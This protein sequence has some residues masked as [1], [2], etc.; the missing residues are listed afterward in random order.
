MK[1]K[2][3]ALLLCLCMSISFLP[4]VALAANNYTVGSGQTYLTLD[5]LRTVPITWSSGDIINIT[6]D[7][8]SLTSAFNFGTNNITIQGNGV[9]EPAGGSTTRFAAER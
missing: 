6:E 9:I 2:V 7:D 8:N 5:A 1:K 3:L 4:T